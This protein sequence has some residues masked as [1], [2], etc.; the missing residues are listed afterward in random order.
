VATSRPRL[1]PAVTGVTL[2]CQRRGVEILAIEFTSHRREHGPGTGALAPS[3]RHAAM[4][5]MRSAA[6]IGLAKKLYDEAQKPENQRRIRE[7]VDKVKAKQ[8]QRRS[9]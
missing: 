2:L 4:K 9:R 5:L 6:A 3:G 1:R 8:A 7:A